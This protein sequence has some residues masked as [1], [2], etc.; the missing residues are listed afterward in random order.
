VEAKASQAEAQNQQD[1]NALIQL[2]ENEKDRQAK[3]L[4]KATA[5]TKMPV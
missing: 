3:I 4:A 1:K 5:P 2:S